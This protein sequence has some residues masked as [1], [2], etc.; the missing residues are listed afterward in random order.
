MNSDE[1][2]L[3]EMLRAVMEPDNTAKSDQNDEMSVSDIMDEMPVSDI[4]DDMLNDV[5]DSDLVDDMLSDIPD[6][7]VPDDVPELSDSDVP[8]FPDMD[9]P[10]DIPEIPASDMMGEMPETLMDM[11]EQKVSEA[12]PD[13][14]E[15]EMSID[16]LALLDMSEDEIDQVLNKEAFGGNAVSEKVPPER[17][18][19]KELS[20]LLSENDELSD[21]QDLLSMADN[22][23]SVAG[24]EIPDDM[25]FGSDVDLD[26]DDVKSLLG[27][28]DEGEENS[29]ENSKEKTVKESKKENTKKEKKSKKKKSSGEEK[30]KKE[31]FGKKLATLFFGS[32]ED[33]LE[34]EAEKEGQS[35]DAAKKKKEK[36]EKK[37]KKKKEKKKKPDKKE[38]PDPKKAAKE[39]QQKEKN[40]EKARKKAEKAEKAEKERRAAKKLPKK[41]VFVW[42][43]LCASIAAGILLMNTVGM[44]TLHLTE[45]RNAFYDKDYETTYE[46]MN[47]RSLNEEDQLLF[48]Q[49]SAILHLK[50][51]EE[52]YENHLKMEKP[53]MAL[54]DLMKGVDKYQ[55]I[56]RTGEPEVITPELI[57]E[58]QNILKILQDKYSLSEE[59]AWEINAL[60]DDYAYS[61]QLEALVN[62]EIYQ[63]QA[64]IERQEAEEAEEE[65][66]HSDLEDILPEEEEYL[67]DS[68]N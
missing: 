39:K 35:E 66:E 58:Y 11:E 43:L 2:R 3:E 10:E 42:V 48:M 68:G 8:E 65:A 49:S 7:D 47:G 52:V 23:E 61:L 13:V 1:E 62:G 40:A 20:D 36:A 45:A 25:P 46:L 29:V 51:A 67:N 27:L 64:E 9:L 22:H 59:G 38:G 50:H 4:T 14:K 17:M 21:I 63:T 57:E 53:V 18:E 55:E 54:E 24:E 32:D 28:T 5:F 44:D 56:V 31:G 34:E 19:D 41:K 60:K 6:S 26:S 12:M 37:E 30:E 33:D 16:P 15:D